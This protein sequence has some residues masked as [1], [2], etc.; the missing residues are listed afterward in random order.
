MGV[1]GALPPAGARG[2]PASFLLLS[3]KGFVEREWGCKGAKPP[4]GGTGVSPENLFLYTIK[5]RSNAW[6]D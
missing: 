4:A 2:V 5:K 3:K 6:Q 1:Q